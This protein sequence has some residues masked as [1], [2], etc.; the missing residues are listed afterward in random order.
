MRV[1][2]LLEYLWLGLS[3]EKNIQTVTNSTITAASTIVTTSTTANGELQ[4]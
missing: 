2:K 1:Y 3:G 4:P